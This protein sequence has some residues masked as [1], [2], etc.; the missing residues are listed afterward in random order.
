[1][2]QSV[3]LLAAA[4]VLLALIAVCLREPL[5]VALPIFAAL[6]PFGQLVAFAEGPF[7]SLSSLMGL[8]LGAGLALQLITTRRTAERLSLSVPIWLLFLGAAG[9]SALWSVDRS[10][11]IRGF[12]VLGSL[13]LVYVLLATSHVDRSVLRR[14]ENGLLA[15]ALTVVAYGLFQLTVLG[16][17]PDGAPEAGPEPVDSG[18]FGNDLLGPGVQAVALLLPLAIALSRSFSAS[19]RS[20]R[21][22]HMLFSGLFIMGVLMTGSR[23]GTLAAGIV[24]VVM[25]LSSPRH[26]RPR[27]LAFLGVGLVISTLVWVYQPAG[28]A[29]RSFESATS[30]SGRTDIWQVGLAACADYCASGSGW[31]TFPTVYAETLASVPDARVLVGGE[32]GTYQPHN[33]W[34][35]A[36]VELGLIGLIL[37]AA[38]LVVAVVEA[39]RLPL[40]RRGP[41]LSAV[42]SMIFAVF[43]LSSMEFKFFWIVFIMVALH[44]NLADAETSSPAPARALEPA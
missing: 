13:I 30:S 43:F 24:L 26:A 18:R 14:T 11:T 8:V 3:L 1:M 35:L 20:A 17:F 25:V 41:P 15:G 12:A 39:L 9:A 36:G 29:S 28:V 16:G 4:P 32:G 42:V 31:G 34:L 21:L 22:L 5:R 7:G 10:L 40:A 6:I 27:L 33:L 19:Q 23:T 37:L 38:G 2:T 44:R